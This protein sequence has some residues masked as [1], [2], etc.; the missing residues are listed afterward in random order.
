MPTRCN[1]LICVRN[2]RR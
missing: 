2:W 1:A